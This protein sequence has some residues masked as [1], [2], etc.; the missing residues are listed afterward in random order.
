MWALCSYIIKLIAR[1]FPFV[2]LFSFNFPYNCNAYRLAGKMLASKIDYSA[3]NSADR[4]YPN[5]MASRKE[6]WRRGKRREGKQHENKT[7][8]QHLELGFKTL[9][10]VSDQQKK[11]WRYESERHLSYLNLQVRQKNTS[12]VICWENYDL[13]LESYYCL[14]KD[15]CFSERKHLWPYKWMRCHE[16]WPVGRHNIS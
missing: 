7:R 12:K 9:A 8:K 2:F 10:A 11:V 16:Q 4:I 14:R 1:Y 6:C 5:L 3:R 13:S 15:G